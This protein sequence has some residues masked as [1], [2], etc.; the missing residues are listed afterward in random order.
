MGN[1]VKYRMISQGKWLTTSLLRCRRLGRN[2]IAPVPSRGQMRSPEWCR[3]KSGKWNGTMVRTFVALNIWSWCMRNLRLGL[4]E[5]VLPHTVSS[6][7]P[8]LE[9]GKS[10]VHLWGEFKRKTNIHLP[11][12]WPLPREHIRQHCI[13]TFSFCKTS[14]ESIK[15]GQFVPIPGWGGVADVFLLAPTSHTLVQFVDLFD[16]PKLTTLPS[17]CWNTV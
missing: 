15:T 3:A 13:S 7:M 11:P 2:K 8:Y 6:W 5:S 10:L 12:L 17:L 4:S 1:L 9:P 14:W 16:R